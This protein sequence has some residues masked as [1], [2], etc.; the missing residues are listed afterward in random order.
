V[1]A[2][3][4]DVVLA[5]VTATLHARETAVMSTVDP[6]ARVSGRMMGPQADFGPPQESAGEG[7]LLFAAIILAIVGVLNVIY[8][9]AAI[10]DS[11]FFVGDTKFILSG[12]NTWGWVSVILGALQLIACV[13]VVRGG[14]FGRWFGIVVAGLHAIAALLSLPAYPFWSLAVFAVDLLIVYGLAVYGGRRRA[15]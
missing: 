5:P 10:T 3:A 6:N 14:Q 8:G 12:L 1:H 9:I 15:A 2:T 13:S 4:P 11:S 7:W